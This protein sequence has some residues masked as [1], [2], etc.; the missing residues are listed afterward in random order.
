MCIPD[1]KETRIKCCPYL[2]VLE[3]N[4]YI[5]VYFQI[6]TE[7]QSKFRVFNTLKCPVSI[8][9][10]QMFSQGCYR[11]T[12]AVFASPQPLVQVWVLEWQGTS[13]TVP[14]EAR[15]RRAVASDPNS[16]WEARTSVGTWQPH[17]PFKYQCW[18]PS[19]HWQMFLQTALWHTQSNGL[20]E[21]SCCQTWKIIW[22][23]T[24][25]RILQPAPSL[26][27]NPREG[28]IA[29][30]GCVQTGQF[31]VSEHCRTHLLPCPPAPPSLVETQIFLHGDELLISLLPLSSLYS[32]SA[33]GQSTRLYLKKETVFDSFCYTCGKKKLSLPSGTLRQA[34]L[35]LWEPCARAP[36]Q[37]NPPKQ[38]AS[39]PDYG[40]H[41]KANQWKLRNLDPADCPKHL[42]P[43]GQSAYLERPLASDKY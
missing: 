9:L 23:S 12:G 21:H 14:W 19:L 31:R 3:L 16:W 13:L 11:F 15:F 20:S 29:G 22:K 42:P 37:C 25:M 40:S 17:T 30:M 7:R 4:T 1:S 2:K 8:A 5:K 10:G 41:S 24:A 38:A 39:N 27:V 32:N 34:S 35:P 36:K 6:T 26:G 28:D 18:T 33:K 43:A